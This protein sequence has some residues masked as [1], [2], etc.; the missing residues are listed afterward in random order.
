M[1]LPEFLTP[2]PRVAPRC[3]IVI[4][5]PAEVARTVL[6]ALRALAKGNPTVHGYL[7]G[8]DVETRP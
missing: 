4:P 6:S 5:V 3:A 2:S 7:L 8:A 1:T